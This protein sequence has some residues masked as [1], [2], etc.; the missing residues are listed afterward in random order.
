M[1]NLFRHIRCAYRDYRWSKGMERQE[2]IVKATPGHSPLL[3][4]INQEE[5]L[6]KVEE[7]NIDWF[8]SQ[9]ESFSLKVNGIMYHCM[10]MGVPICDS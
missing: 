7:V 1:F 10:V 9:P 4:L 3:E 5:P 8:G 6:S 2:L